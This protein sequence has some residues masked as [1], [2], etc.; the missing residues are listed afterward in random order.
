[1]TSCAAEPEKAEASEIAK[2]LSLSSTQATRPQGLETC[3][4][5]HL[6]CWK[7]VEAVAV[8][9]EMPTKLRND[10]CHDIGASTGGETDNQPHRLGRIGL[11]R[12]F[13]TPA[14]DA[15]SEQREQGQAMHHL[16]QPARG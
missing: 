6:R 1:M 9:L 4:R 15:Q 14:G 5:D 8:V 11:G 12:R 7:R 2:R 16:R 10:A 13:R 3:A